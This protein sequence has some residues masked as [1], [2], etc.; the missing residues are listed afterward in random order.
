[1]GVVRKWQF[2]HIF[3]TMESRFKKDLNFQVRFF[4]RPTGVSVQ[5]TLDLRKKKWTF[6]YPDSPIKFI[7]TEQATKGNNFPHIWESCSPFCKTS[8][9]DLSYGQIYDRDFHPKFWPSQIT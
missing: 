3:S 8:T 4:F 9:V 1:M 2:L 6:L 5:T 7:Y